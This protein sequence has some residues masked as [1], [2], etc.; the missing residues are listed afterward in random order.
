MGRNGNGAAALGA[1]LVVAATPA[2]AP[3]EGV[4]FP[5]RS[6]V[7]IPTAGTN[8]AGLL[9]TRTRAFPGGG[10][11]LRLDIGV[12]P[13]V[14]AGA[15]YGGVQII[16]DGSPDWNPRPGLALKVRVLPETFSTPALALGVDTQGS[17]FY[18]GG[19][20]RY[21]YQSK[22]LFAVASKNYAWLGDFTFHGGVYRTFEGN[23]RDPSVFVGAE[24]S[25]GQW[26]RLGMEYDLALSDDRDDGAFGKGRGY[27]NGVLGW[28]LSSEVEVRFVVRDMLRNSETIDPSL[29]DVVVDEGFGRE[30]SFSY[31]ER[32]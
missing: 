1:A 24:K 23:D 8:P 17:G 18:D 31:A 20:G 19:R 27:L 21:Q 29:T 28:R 4:W 30:V 16:G 15:S 26:W 7:D 32:F 25:L 2:L 22:G 13:W 5:P 12:L 10:L 3:A 11:E 14:T 9:D 6:L